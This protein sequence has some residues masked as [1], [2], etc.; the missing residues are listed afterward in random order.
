M[1]HFKHAL[2]LALLGTLVSAFLT[3][4]APNTDTSDAE[5]G[6]VATTTTNNTGTNNDNGGGK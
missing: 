5:L 4:C 3:G 2:L 1:S 6:N